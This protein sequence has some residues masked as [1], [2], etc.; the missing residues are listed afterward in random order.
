MIKI[1]AGKYGSRN[2]QTL[3]GDNTRPTSN[4]VRGAIF[5][6]V[7]PY[8]DRGSSL[9]L[10]AG[11]GAFSFEAL[12]RG[13][14]DAYLVDN[15]RNA[16]NIIKSNSN[17]L[18]VKTNIIQK[19]Y[20]AALE[21]LKDKKFDLIFLDPPYKLRVIEDVI[22]FIDSNNM[23]KKDGVIVV[24][25]LK[26]YQMIEKIGNII[27]EKEVTYGISKISYYRWSD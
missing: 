21:L 24:E 19:D 10:F 16:I 20:K 7:G 15:N 6:K 1:I 12:S 11:S 14:S 5:S 9:D 23:L 13:I 18:D 2:I 25:T 17:I 4:K 8:F 26:D 22:E 27:I 3:Q